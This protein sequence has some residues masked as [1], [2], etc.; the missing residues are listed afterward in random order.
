M[1]TEHVLCV[2]EYLIHINQRTESFQRVPHTLD[3][4]VV[5]TWKH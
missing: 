3:N 5:K 4:P 1:L 2:T